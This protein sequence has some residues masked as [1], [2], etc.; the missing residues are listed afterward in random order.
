M[1]I[2]K[3]DGMEGNTKDI[4]IEILK[5]NK[6]N[7]IEIETDNE[8]HSFKKLTPIGSDIVINDIRYKQKVFTPIVMDLCKDYTFVGYPLSKPDIKT[9][10]HGW[11]YGSNQEVIDAL[12]NK[13]T[14][15]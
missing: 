11:F 8:V 9:L 5:N 14:G 6:R 1:E 4:D 3:D 10:N 2:K 15:K 12:V 7:V 13:D